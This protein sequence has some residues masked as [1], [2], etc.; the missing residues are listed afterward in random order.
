MCSYIIAIISYIIAI[1]AMISYTIA[2]SYYTI[3]YMI[4]TISGLG[5]A[6]E[7]REESHDEAGR[8]H[9]GATCMQTRASRVLR[10]RILW[11]QVVFIME[12]GY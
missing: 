1:I 4:A 10:M 3:S 6:P 8:L 12:A 11:R 2:I 7:G 9:Y 5:G